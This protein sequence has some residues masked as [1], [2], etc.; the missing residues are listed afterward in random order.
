MAALPLTRHAFH[1]DW[2]YVLHPALVGV[3]PA[4]E[5]VLGVAWEQATLSDPTLTGMS[6][7]DLNVLTASLAALHEAQ[8]GAGMGRPPRLPFPEQVL[9]TVLHLRL[10]LPAEP[11]AV[12]ICRP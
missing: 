8:P 1:G 6:Q 7:H 4:E 11:L 9:A 5:H 2:N 3:S 12:L 10:G